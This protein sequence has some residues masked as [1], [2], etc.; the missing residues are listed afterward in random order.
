MQ[1]WLSLPVVIGVGIIILVLGL[2]GVILLK[3]FSDKID[4]SQLIAESDGKASLSRFQFLIFTFVIAG[5]YLLLCIESGTF[6][7]IPASVLGLMGISGGSYVVSK[8]ITANVTNAAVTHGKK[9]PGDATK[10]GDKTG[11]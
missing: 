1:P 8:G 10:A 4:I 3:I 11:A 7:E 9:P 6:I 5:L 2:A